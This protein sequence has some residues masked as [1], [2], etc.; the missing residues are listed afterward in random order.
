MPSRVVK[1]PT[2]KRSRETD[3]DLEDRRKQRSDGKEVRGGGK[4]LNE[5]SPRRIRASANYSM[6]CAV[7]QSSISARSGLPNSWQ[8]RY[9]RFASNRIS[10]N[11]S[12]RF[13]S[14]PPPLPIIVRQSTQRRGASRPE[15][16]RVQK[17]DAS[18]G[19]GDGSRNGCIIRT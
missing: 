10:A 14:P 9:A 19:G 5:G 6:N 7:K 17:F 1:S 16:D 13:V 12:I 2:S 4:E 15:Q 18:F 11:Y 3:I 8:I